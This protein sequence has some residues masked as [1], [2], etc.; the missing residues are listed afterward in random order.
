MNFNLPD[1]PSSRSSS[2]DA[3]REL[4][5]LR[6]RTRELE[7]VNKMLRGFVEVLEQYKHD[8]K[9]ELRALAGACTRCGQGLPGH[10]PCFGTDEEEEPSS[11]D[12]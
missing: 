2:T 8:N 10:Q 11:D 1:R 12:E 5:Y 9:Y 6:Q 3:A 7:L 4:H